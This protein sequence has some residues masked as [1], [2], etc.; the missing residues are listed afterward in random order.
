MK[1]EGGREG[2]RKERKENVTMKQNDLNI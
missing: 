1:Q 2:R